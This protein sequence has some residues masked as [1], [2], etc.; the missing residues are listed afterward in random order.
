MEGFFSTMF[1]D[2][3]HERSLVILRSLT[4]PNK[5]K[6]CKFTDHEINIIKNPALERLHRQ[7]CLKDYFVF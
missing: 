4:D 1:E 2:A 5:L 6:Q 7:K 3:R